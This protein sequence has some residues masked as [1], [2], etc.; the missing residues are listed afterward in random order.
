MEVVTWCPNPCGGPILTSVGGPILNPGVEGGEVVQVIAADNILADFGLWL[1]R[2]LRIAQI[3]SLL[4][5]AKLSPCYTFLIG[6]SPLGVKLLTIME[7][8]TP[9]T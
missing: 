7:I 4:K 5:G 9:Q 1:W 6:P 3:L 2:A 8:P